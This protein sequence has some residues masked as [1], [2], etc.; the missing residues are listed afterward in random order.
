VRID[1]STI[2]L[3]SQHVATQTHTR[4]ETLT[5]GVVT[6]AWEADGN[7][8]DTREVRQRERTLPASGSTNARTLLDEYLGS[9]GNQAGDMPAADDLRQALDAMDS[10]RDRLAGSA[11]MVTSSLELDGMGLLG[12]IAELSA[13]ELAG[14]LGQ[15]QTQAQAHVQPQASAADRLKMDLI[16]STVETFTGRKLELLDLA[17]LESG[18]A[19]HTNGTVAAPRADANAPA[20]GESAEAAPE[21][22]FGL[23]YTVR[24]TRTER[25][26]TSFQAKG[27]VHTADGREIDIEV[28][29]TMDREF[30][31]ESSA[32]V[33]VGAALEDPLVVNF[34]GTAAQLTQRTF[35]FDLDANGTAEDIHFVGPGSGFLAWDRNGSGTVEDG[36]ELFG[37]A[38]GQGFA[39]LAAH[40]DDGNG[41]IDEG[42]AIYGDLRIWEKDEAGTDKLVALQ[43]RGVGAIYLGSAATP[44]EV[45]DDEGE[46]QGVVRS[47]GMYLR[48]DGGAGTV[49]QLDLVV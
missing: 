20:D 38:T 14:A 9:A 41:F 24:D 7:G 42:D 16:R 5:A 19:T 8:T 27:V 21:P 46:L 31:Q 12:Q 39:E 15:I 11:A 34:E 47:T 23:T 40:D 35:A 29:L 32:E 25:E 2:A 22:R 10:G 33:R 43:A 37:P 30:I 45:K 44:F 3:S 36:S 6:G 17:D 18:G 26:T 13:G 4:Q 1:S 28:S 48:E 49:Q